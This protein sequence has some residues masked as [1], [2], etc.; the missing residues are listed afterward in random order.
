MKRRRSPCEP[1][2]HRPVE[3]TRCLPVHKGAVERENRGTYP[4]GWTTRPRCPSTSGLPSTAAG[5]EPS[6]PTSRPLWL[7]RRVVLG[8]RGPSDCP[9]DRR[10]SYRAC[11]RILRVRHVGSIAR[12]EA[13]DS[14]RQ[15]IRWNVCRKFR[16]RPK[17]QP[18]LPVGAA[19]VR[20]GVAT[21]GAN[22]AA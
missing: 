3:T 14:L 18:C 20:H 12:T 10:D 8:C 6:S 22:D 13:R 4:G 9:S 5:H 17:P 1:S 7:Y 19:P 15:A 21:K 11:G 2:E 16:G